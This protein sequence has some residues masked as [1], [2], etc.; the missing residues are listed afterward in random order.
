M[1]TSSTRPHHPG[2]RRAT[3]S[4]RLQ[5]GRPNGGP[6]AASPPSSAAGAYTLAGLTVVLP[7]LDEEANVAEA[8]HA[9][10]AAAAVAAHESEIVVVD[11]GSTDATAE[12]AARLA[13]R[14][15][16]RVRLVTHPGNRGYG[17][18][19]RSGMQA[20]RMPWVLLTD[21]DLQ[22]D[23]RQLEDLLP[24]TATSDLIVGWR[25]PREDPLGRRLCADAWNWLVRRL[26][27]L[28]VRDVD[29][30]F[31]LVRRDVVS[32]LELHAEGAVISTELLVKALSAGARVTQLAVRH[33]PRP[34]GHQS[35][36]G[37]R[38]IARAARELVGLRGMARVDRAT[39]RSV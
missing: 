9:A 21:A 29:C 18:A 8:V 2:G 12:I 3:P 17:A 27:A 23:L 15:A 34:A 28:P 37:P 19:L 30:A 35:G 10:A 26:F 33:R 16:G 31:K 38:V 1:S 32:A 11:D 4:S 39:V 36:A 6:P 20:A 25:A 22:F 24:F 7:C 13:A 5:P 14:E